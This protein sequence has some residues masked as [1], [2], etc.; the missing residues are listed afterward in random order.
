MR[1]G[2][3]LDRKDMRQATE[4]GRQFGM[5][6]GRRALLA[7]MGGA[8]LA[9]PFLHQFERSARAQPSAGKRAK[10]LIV[11]YSPNGV[12]H[13]A[14]WP[15]GGERDFKLNLAME[16][17]EKYRD[18]LIIVGPQ[19]AGAERKPTA[20]TGLKHMARPP[21]HQAQVFLTGDPVK[22]PYNNQTGDGLTVKTSHPS[23]DQIVA[24]KAPATRFRSLEF[25]L[26]PV[27]G[28]TPSSINFGMDGSPLPRMT[29]AAA[30]WKR[31]FEGVKDSSDQGPMAPDQRRVTVSN[32][33][34]KRFSALQPRLGKDDRLT[35]E[36]HMESLRE[37]EKRVLSGGGTSASCK[38]S[39]AMFTP[40]PIADVPATAANFE[41]MIALA[42]ACDLTRVAS[43]TFGYPGGGGAGGL[44][45]TWLGFSDAHHSLSHHGNQAA[46]L[47]KLKKLMQWFGS[48]V[49]RTLDQLAKY[50]HPDGGSLLDNT[51]VYWASRHGEGNGHTN[52]NIPNL[53]AGGAGGY[54]GTMGR[55]L[56]L[57]GTNYSS[58][59]LTLARAFGVQMDGFG[60][61][62][63]RATAPIA[64]LTA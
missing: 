36:Q 12:Y 26:R 1:A 2:S 27:G 35:V 29:D 14:F 34:A 39:Q 21:Q 15:T 9:L 13:Q 3:P 51:I 31:I 23:L 7:R 11:F 48:Q 40:A 37:V 16:S 52:E 56:N 8:A 18:K 42:F 20:G 46:K 28:D 17:L 38:P 44:H 63:L 54:F 25:G 58:M 50:P 62:A 5:D 33:L 32:F 45:G 30:A 6:A 41:D 49:T 43:I 47:D 61:G 55:F 64:E 60:V 24:A 10:N 53:I 19:F 22:V 59:L 57:P 4:L